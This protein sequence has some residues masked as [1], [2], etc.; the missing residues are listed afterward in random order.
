MQLNDAL[1]ES[2]TATLF[3][4]LGR[5]QQDLGRDRQAESLRFHESS[6]FAFLA[7]LPLRR[8]PCDLMTLSAL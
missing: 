4:H 5:L 3:N 8:G 7:F 1:I 2:W 6:L